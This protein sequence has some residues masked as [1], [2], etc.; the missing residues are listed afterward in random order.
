MGDGM[1]GRELASRLAS[2]RKNEWEIESDIPWCKWPGNR[3][4]KSN[5]NQVFERFVFSTTG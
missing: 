2:E 4:A 1:R 5:K 3:C